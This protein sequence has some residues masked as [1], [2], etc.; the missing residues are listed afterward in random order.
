MNKGKK[1][2]S[3]R[4]GEGERSQRKGEGERSQRKG[5]GECVRACA[6]VSVCFC[7]REKE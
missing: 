4:K 5:E 7:E 6:C 1:E 2:R 3:Q